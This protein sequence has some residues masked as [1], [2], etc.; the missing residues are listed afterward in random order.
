[1]K[2]WEYYTLVITSSNGGIDF[3]DP[4]IN[5][6]GKDG[7]EMVSFILDRK[8]SILVRAVIVF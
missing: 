8:S 5:N 1:M 4:S 7:W 2:K 6:L 3:T